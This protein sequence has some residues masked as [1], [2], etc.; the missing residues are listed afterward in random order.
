MDYKRRVHVSR[1]FQRARL[2]TLA[3]ERRLVHKRDPK[4]RLPLQS[5]KRY[6]H[7]RITRYREV[8]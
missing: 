4:S 3:A 2:L 6:V 1:V 5:A 8:I 7:H